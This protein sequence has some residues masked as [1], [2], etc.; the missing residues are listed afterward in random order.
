MNNSKRRQKELYKTYPLFHFMKPKDFLWMGVVMLIFFILAVWNL[1]DTKEP[2][3]YLQCGQDGI[4]EVILDFGDYMYISDMDVF[5][6]CKDNIKIAL[7]VYDEEVGEW[8]VIDDNIEVSS[9]FAWNRKEINIYG[10]YMGLVFMDENAPVNEITFLDG[11]GNVC[12][13]C[14]A[15]EYTEIFDEV[16]LHPDYI[17]YKNGTMFDEV[18]HGR[19]AYEF[20][21]HLTTYETTHP[22][23]GKI[24]IALG[25]ELF[26]MSPFGMRISSVIMGTLMIGF[27]GLLAKRLTHDTW[28]SVAATILLGADFMHYTLS[29]I[30]TIDVHVCF[31]IVGMYYFMFA[32]LQENKNN[33]GNLKYSY[34]LL[35]LSGL[36]MGFGCAT[37]FTGIF[38]GAGLGIIFISY[39]I[40]H[41]PKDNWFKLMILCIVSFIVVPL[42]IYTLGFIPVVE[43]VKTP[44]LIT[45]TIEGTKS[46][47]SYHSGLDATH[48]YSSKWYTWPFVIRPLLDAYNVVADDKRS[49]V[50]TMGNPIIYYLGIVC[51][52]YQAVRIFTKKDTKA[53][54]LFVAYFTQ[55]MPWWFVGRIC[56][57]YHYFPSSVFLMV[58]IGYTIKT[59]SDKTKWGKYAGYVLVTASVM[60][61]VIY[62]PAISGLPVKYDYLNA[63]TILNSW[64]LT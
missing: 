32:Y 16:Y 13:P 28:C 51:L 37:K 15:D 4:K 14:N 12:I 52:L 10:R 25:I 11:E 3:T 6:N 40:K 46:M 58:I 18:Y 49:S 30:A 5:L 29:R 55:Y 8:N 59:I 48:S 7:S 21:H 64:T 63:L 33:K 22:H 38:A 1:G 42:I 56:F 17:S 23:L 31:F 60:A 39:L 45:R 26:G 35:A 36:F 53:L 41:F 50:S 62:F 2:K 9:V 61:F 20:I 24:I 44:N 19:T 57:I 34:L 43:Y 27:V 47:I 54:F